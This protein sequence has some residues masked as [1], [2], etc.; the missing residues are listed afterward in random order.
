[1]LSKLRGRGFFLFL[2]ILA[3]SLTYPQI[4]QVCAQEST[5]T[6]KTLVDDFK[7]GSGLPIG[8]IRMV[9]DQVIV[10]HQD[11]TTG[12]VAETGLP[13]YEGDTI[14]TTDHGRAK[15]GLVDGSRFSMAA[16]TKI[17]LVQNI[18]N[19]TRK[20]SK[21]S[22]LME[23]GKARFQVKNLDEFVL[24]EF[25][26]QT[27]T[28]ILQTVGTAQ[29]DMLVSIVTGRTDVTTLDNTRL[30]ISSMEETESQIVLSDFQRTVIEKD[31]L[32]AIV[33]VLDTA[34]VDAQ[35]A[36]LQLPATDYSTGYQAT[37]KDAETESAEESS[38][39]IERRS[40]LIER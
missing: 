23:A 11:Q 29:A 38:E 22:I 18:Y 15:A 8:K 32:M 7:P 13:L 25:K 31:G 40:P 1:M 19:S 4:E 14:V 2:A 21:T 37:D 10:F 36:D 30:Q 20:V 17:L 26:I 34:E 5:Q 24:R 35:L 16:G 3:V 33:E 12:Y 39:I 27:P 6:P 28:A 9:R